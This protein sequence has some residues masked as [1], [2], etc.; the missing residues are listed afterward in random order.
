MSLISLTASKGEC[1]GA[2]G[3]VQLSQSLNRF[4]MR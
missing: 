4:S 1:F 2:G 3:R